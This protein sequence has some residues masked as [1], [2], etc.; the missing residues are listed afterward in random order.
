MEDVVTAEHRALF[1]PQRKV[2]LEQPPRFPFEL[3]PI[4]AGTAIFAYWYRKR[5]E[6][7]KSGKHK[8]DDN[9]KC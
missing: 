7:I 8:K 9:D 4:A 2:V 5:S 1:A 3:F 6:L